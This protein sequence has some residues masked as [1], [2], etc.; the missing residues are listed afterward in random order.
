[1]DTPH[2]IRWTDRD[3]R[4][5]FMAAQRDW[6]EWVY[7][8][9]VQAPLSRFLAVI[10][11]IVSAL[12]VWCEATV[13]IREPNLSVISHLVHNDD[14]SRLTVQMVVV[15]FVGYICF[16]AYS[17]L[18]RVDLFSFYRLTPK[19]SDPG[20]LLFN[21]STLLRLAPSICYNYLYLIHESS[22]TAFGEIFKKSEDLPLVGRFY[23][24][25]FPMVTLAVVII[26]LLNLDGKVR[27]LI[28]FYMHSIHCITYTFITFI[29]CFT[30]IPYITYITCMIC[31]PCI[32]C[33][34]YI[35]YICLLFTFTFPLGFVV[36]LDP[37]VL[38]R[39]VE[40]PT[41]HR[42]PF[43]CRSRAAKEDERH[44]H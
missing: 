20:S 22:T 23:G 26:T 6:L 27:E 25:Y 38:R 34:P 41:C 13:F 16:C 37:Q 17:T 19:G 30:C 21:T 33:I 11:G 15:G 35:T 31:I 14:F 18:F 9:R 24:N 42:G 2:A 28:A 1:M 3:R 40:R 8:I 29:S 44:R 10:T 32:P 39:D 7:I 43:R 36:V 4:S 5:G 12:V